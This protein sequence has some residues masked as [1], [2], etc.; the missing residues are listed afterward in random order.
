MFQKPLKDVL[1]RLPANLL[2]PW[3]VNTFF[4]HESLNLIYSRCRI[5]SSGGTSQRMELLI[6]M[7]GPKT[8]CGNEPAHI[9]S[10]VLQVRI[11]DG[12]KASLDTMA[13]SFYNDLVQDYN[14]WQTL[15]SYLR[16]VD[17]TTGVCSAHGAVQLKRISKI[18][19]RSM[20]NRIQQCNSMSPMFF[21]RKFLIQSSSVKGM[22]LH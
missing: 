16:D 22:S 1:S 4:R 20:H 8:T 15:M 5:M 13:P 2:I 6:T 11:V 17:I 9:I 3:V 18:F 12:V 14:P 21:I 19:N 10:G 7:S